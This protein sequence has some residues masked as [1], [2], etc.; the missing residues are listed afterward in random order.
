MTEQKTAEIELRESEARKNAIF[1]A[2]MD[3]IIFAGS[4]RADRGV[5]PGGRGDVRLRA[6]RGGRQGIGR[7]CCVPPDLRKRQ[8]ENLL[9][10]SGAGEMGS[11]LGR[12]V[13]IRMLRKNGEVF[14]AE[15][16][17]QPIPLQGSTGF[18]IFVR[19]ITQRKQAEV[20]LRHAKEA[21]EA[22]NVNPRARSWPT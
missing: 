15:M 17:T 22:A 18:A 1:E 3:C 21:A 13:E 19:D 2:A 6:P 7:R 16:A 8:R 11:M 20:A 12:R 9:R 5:Q 10:Y 4:G 14:D